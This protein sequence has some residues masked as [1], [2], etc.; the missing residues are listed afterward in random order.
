MD[1][2]G[3]GVSNV[4]NI[5]VDVRIRFALDERTTVVAGVDLGQRDGFFV[6]IVAVVTPPL[7]SVAVG[8]GRSV[9]EVLVALS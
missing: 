9:V 7:S 3:L 8:E 1:V 5:Y 4:F 6:G 2:A